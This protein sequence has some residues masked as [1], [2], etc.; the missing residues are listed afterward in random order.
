MSHPRGQRAAC[1]LVEFCEC[2]V[3]RPDL[4]KTLE[5]EIK[6]IRGLDEFAACAA[7]ISL[8][9]MNSECSNYSQSYITIETT[10]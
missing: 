3:T 6:K 8:M 2:R 7:L 1:T 5:L 9:I 4:S 10:I